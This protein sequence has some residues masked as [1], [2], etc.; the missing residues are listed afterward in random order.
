[1]GLER[2]TFYTIRCNK[3]SSL[4]EDWT[5]EIGRLTKDNRKLAEELAEEQGFKKI[6]ANTWICPNCIQTFSGR[7]IKRK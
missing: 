2:V 4:L 1:M 3:C 7:D 5:G 6:S